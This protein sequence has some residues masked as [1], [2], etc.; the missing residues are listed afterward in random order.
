MLAI[1][2]LVSLPF[3]NSQGSLKIQTICSEK[4]R[5][6]ERCSNPPSPLALPWH[7]VSSP[8]IALSL[9]GVC[10]QLWDT[11]VLS[12]HPLA[13]CSHSGHP[14][15]L[16]ALWLVTWNSY[17]SSPLS[18]NNLHLREQG[19]QLNHPTGQWTT[20][21]SQLKTWTPGVRCGWRGGRRTKYGCLNPW[22]GD[23]TMSL[24]GAVGV[25]DI[26]K[27]SVSNVVLN[28]SVLQ[29]SQW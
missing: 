11:S 10:V 23:G 4:T 13:W 26:L 2:S 18:F 1:W 8:L 27:L 21:P 25:K 6:T 9:L 16:F 3:L 12:P 22:W 7:V 20:G 17:R 24:K 28:T 5:R 14:C 29:K 19:T 15:P